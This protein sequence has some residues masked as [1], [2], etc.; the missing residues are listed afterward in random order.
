MITWSKK[1]RKRSD[2]LLMNTDRCRI[3]R[4]TKFRMLVSS[5]GRG[6]IGKMIYGRKT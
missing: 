6:E 4:K 5:G 2:T 1:L 3:V